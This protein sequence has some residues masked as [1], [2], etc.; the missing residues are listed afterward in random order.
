M[1]GRPCPANWLAELGSS[2]AGGLVSP[3]GP[4]AREPGGRLMRREARR[5]RVGEAKVT[6]ALT[7]AG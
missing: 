7:D 3:S 2:H 6:Y 4:P 5:V 1:P